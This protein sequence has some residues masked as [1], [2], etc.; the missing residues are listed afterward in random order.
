MAFAGAKSG[1]LIFAAREKDIEMA[2]LGIAGKCVKVKLSLQG[3][4]RNIT[5]T[6][7]CLPSS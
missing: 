3:E 2:W 6:F 7:Q 1:T 5:G 4:N